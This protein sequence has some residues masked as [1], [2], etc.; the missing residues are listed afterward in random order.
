[1]ATVKQFFL[2][3]PEGGVDRSAQSFTL[4]MG[5]FWYL[6]NL[7]PWQK[8]L[9]QTPLF[10][11]YA[12]LSSF[13]AVASGALRLM[14]PLLKTDGALVYFAL[15]EV[16]A[17]FIDPSNFAT[18]TKLQFVLQTAV[19][20]NPAV[21][22]QVL[23]YNISN[24]GIAVDDEIE[25][26]IVDATHFK[27]R[28]NGGSWSADTVIANGVTI[29]TSMYLGFLATTGFNTGDTWKWKS[30]TTPYQGL[31]PSFQVQNAMYKRDCYIAG[32]DRNVLRL[33]DDCVTTVG[34]KRIYG[35]Y[36]VVFYN[37]LVIA[38]FAEGVYDVSTGVKDGY[39]A[40]T[41]PW[42]VAWSDRDN[43]DNFFATDINEADGKDL[44]FGDTDDATALGVT[45]MEC[46]RN[47]VFFFLS[48]EMYSMTY[49]GL[50][51]VM[52]IECLNFNVGSAFQHGVVKTP[53][54]LFFIS[55]DNICMFDGTS[56]QKVGL[57]FRDIFFAEIPGESDTNRQKLFGF[58]DK[59]KSEVVWTYLT[60]VG[61]YLQGR[62]MILQLDTGDIY[63]RNTPSSAMTS[64]L[65]IRAICPVIGSFQKLLYGGNGTTDILLDGV[66][67]DA[68]N[69]SANFMT[70]AISIA[71]AASFTNPE[72]QT[73]DCVF[74]NISHVKEVD[75]M[76]LDASY[77]NGS[78][79]EVSTSARQYA[80]DKSFTALSTAWVTTVPEGRLSLPRTAFRVISYKFKCLGSLASNYIIRSWGEWILGAKDTTEK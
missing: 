48:N 28:L 77:D 43:P 29:N 51:N 44:P 25:V 6:L 49:V 57:K 56:I 65:S 69:N 52:Q 31:F 55:K 67:A 12:T 5:T 72:A 78:G 79:I 70:D 26:T 15:D 64:S 47:Q 20:S 35:K 38:H 7:R 21:Q 54:G 60:Y 32:Y 40:Q 2:R 80:S 4:P 19:P 8:K 68:S 22:G 61:T 27:W 37:H 76:F 50:P 58:F 34:Y 42:R 1:M 3:V 10:R 14:K 45:G 17:R 62:Q 33:R 53:A 39:N 24:V 11:K 63:F 18:Q 16:H 13:S 74:D 59:Q 73:Q 23:L 71:G 36:V 46:Y 9:T 30:T 66:A 41:T 75:S